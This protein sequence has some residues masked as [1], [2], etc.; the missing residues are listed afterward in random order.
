M[1]KR[2]RRTAAAAMNRNPTAHPI[3]PSGCRPQ[4]KA[5]I[6]GAMPNEITSASESNSM[7]KSLVA[8]A[9]RAT[10]PSSM[11]STMAKPMS[12]AAVANSPRIA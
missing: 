5:R 11:S 9:I 8:F 3:R 1:L 7:P 12:G 10:R 2:A 6:A 4:L